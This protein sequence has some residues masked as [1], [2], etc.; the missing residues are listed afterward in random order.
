[1]IPIDI[2]PPKPDITDA[3]PTY[4]G[5]D[6][7]APS[8]PGPSRPPHRPPEPHSAPQPSLPPQSAPKPPLSSTPQKDEDKGK[9]QQKS[10]DFIG[11]VKKNPVKSAA[12]AVGVLAVL[13]AGVWFFFLK[14]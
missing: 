4:R 14:K 8:Y 6:P 9:L 13:G 5:E 7:E 3:P 12:I 2:V 10:T 1:M 11:L